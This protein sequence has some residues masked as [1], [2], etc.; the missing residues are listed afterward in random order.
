[1]PEKTTRTIGLSASNSL[2]RVPAYLVTQY[3]LRS[4]RFRNIQ[5]HICRC[6]I[7]TAVELFRALCKLQCMLV[8]TQWFEP[9]DLRHQLSAKTVG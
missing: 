8:S 2:N 3:F 1:M 7:T 9:Q 4:C 6:C 5:L